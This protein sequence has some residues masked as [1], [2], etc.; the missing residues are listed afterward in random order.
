MKHILTFIVLG[1]LSFWSVTFAQSTQPTVTPPAGA[2]GVQLEQNVEVADLGITNSGTLP[3]SSWYIVKEWKRRMERMFTFSADKKFELDMRVSNEKFAEIL[4]VEKKYPSNAKAFIHALK[5]YH[6][7]QQKLHKQLVAVKEDASSPKLEVALTKLD[8]QSLLHASLLGQAEARWRDDPYAEDASRV[9]GDDVDLIAPA[10]RGVRSSIIDS[11]TAIVERQVDVKDKAE[12]ELV[13]AESEYN[14]LKVEV[15]KLEAEIKAEGA[16]A[17]KEQGIRMAPLHSGIESGSYTGTAIA[18]REQGV[19][20]TE[21][22]IDEPGVHRVDKTSASDASAGAG[23]AG[24]K[25][26]TAPVRIDNTPARI[27][28]NMTIGRQ[29]QKRDFGDRMK[30]GLETA[31]GM[32]AQGRSAFAE[33][34]FGEAFGQARAV[35]VLVKNTMRAISEFAIKEQGVKSVNPL[36][37]DEGMKGDSPLYEKKTDDVKPPCPTLPGA[38]D[39]CGDTAQQ[40]PPTVSPV[41]PRVKTELPIVS[42]PTAPVACTMEAKLCPDGSAVGRTGPACEFSAC[43]TPLPG[44]QISPEKPTGV[45]MCTAQYDPVCGSDGKTYGNSCEAGVASVSVVARGECGGTDATGMPKSSSS[46]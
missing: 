46:I 9:G 5:N 4:A 41:I 44:T 34:K 45:I 2:T 10:L 38:P 21:I 40:S 22:A 11:W 32:L 31:G 3:T 6:H 1:M 39:K 43:P 14:L 7:A 27:S 37:E 23:S 19:R 42:K 24:D 26:K 13:R 12:A 16:I 36:Y 25:E 18:I 15:A 30:A 8:K 35:S 17:I 20:K 33:G 29:T 28:T